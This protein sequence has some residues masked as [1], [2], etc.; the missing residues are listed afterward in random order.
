M[1]ISGKTGKL[2]RVPNQFVVTADGSGQTVGKPIE[3]KSFGADLQNVKNYLARVKPGSMKQTIEMSQRQAKA[4]I[5]SNKY[6]TLS[7]LK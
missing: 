4:N 2:K 3:K 6:K 5:E 1:T 7:D